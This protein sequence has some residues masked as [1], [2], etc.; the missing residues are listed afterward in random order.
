MGLRVPQLG[1]HGDDTPGLIVY[2]NALARVLC[3]DVRVA[4]KG[5]GTGM[6][7]RC[8]GRREGLDEQDD[9]SEPVPATP[10]YRRVVLPRTVLGHYVMPSRGRWYNLTVRSGNCSRARCWSPLLLTTQP[11]TCPY[12][13]GWPSVL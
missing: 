12:A 10:V 1:V 2:R 9:Q 5:L 3:L 7:D 11:R 8:H 4:A 6:N 13:I